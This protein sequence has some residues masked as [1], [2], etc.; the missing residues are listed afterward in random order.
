MYRIEND[1][2]LVGW[3]GWDEIVINLIDW[4]WWNKMFVFFVWVSYSFLV[5]FKLV[6]VW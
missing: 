3:K 6:V 5:W 2:G 1:L 4:V